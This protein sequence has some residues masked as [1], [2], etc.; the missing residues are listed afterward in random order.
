MLKFKCG[1]TVPPPCRALLY[2][3]YI[4]L[5]ID[6]QSDHIE[7]AYNKRIAS[8]ITYKNNTRAIMTILFREISKFYKFTLSQYGC[9]YNTIPISAV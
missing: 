4:S 3:Q 9:P 6:V 8:K 5:N 7:K 2:Q 1:I